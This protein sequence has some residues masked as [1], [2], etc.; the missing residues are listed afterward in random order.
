[1]SEEPAVESGSPSSTLATS[2]AAHDFNNLITVIESYVTELEQTTEHPENL[3]MLAGILEATGRAR[4][5]SASLLASGRRD[6]TATQRSADLHQCIRRTMQL[7]QRLMR[8]DVAVELSLASEQIEVSLSASQVDQV[9]FNLVINAQDAMPMGGTMHIA[10]RYA[11]R[12]TEV[13]SP[14]WVE[15]RVGDT[16]IGMN[17]ETQRRLF[18]PFYTTKDVGKGSGLG[19]SIVHDRVA[20]AGGHISVETAVGQGSTFRVW[21]PLERCVRHADGI[22]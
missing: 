16:G 13:D 5:L 9:L 17:E 7:A 1:M 8:P 3:A 15:L 18:E 20:A 4:S 10:T 12:D 6:H 14:A 21:L 22:Q 11:H 2:S 19:L